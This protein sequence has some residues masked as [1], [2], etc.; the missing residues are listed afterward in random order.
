MEDYEL[1][2]EAFSKAQSVDPEYALAWAGQGLCAG[3]LSTPEQALELFEHAYEISEQS[4]VHRVRRCCFSGA[5]LT[6]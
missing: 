2:N 1:A 6:P 4:Y 5:M 3:L